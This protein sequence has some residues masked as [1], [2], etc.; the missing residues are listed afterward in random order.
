MAK[1]AVR[2]NLNLNFLSD[3]SLEE[4]GNILKREQ[5]SAVGI[6]K[7]KDLALLFDYTVV[8]SYLLNK[9]AK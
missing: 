5:L 7:R 8:K 3:E 6:D 9:N 1:R 2:L 4:L